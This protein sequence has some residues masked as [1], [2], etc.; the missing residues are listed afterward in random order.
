MMVNKLNDLIERQ[1]KLVEKLGLATRLAFLEIG[2]M[3][4]FHDY[5]DLLDEYADANKRLMYLKELKESYGDN[6][7][8]AEN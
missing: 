5:T 3:G 7:V 8:L 4:T 1:E 6:V 2:E